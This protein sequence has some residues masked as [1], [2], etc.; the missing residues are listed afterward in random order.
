MGA[1]RL[2]QMDVGGRGFLLRTVRSAAQ[3]GG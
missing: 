2:K 3:D 1:E